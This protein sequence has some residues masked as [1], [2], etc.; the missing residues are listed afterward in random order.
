M[1]HEIA[2]RRLHLRSENVEEPRSYF[3]ISRTTRLLCELATITDV[4]VL[5]MEHCADHQRTEA[6]TTDGFSTASTRKCE[7]I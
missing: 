7:A 4:T 1:R 6:Q 2:L 3:K 5:Q